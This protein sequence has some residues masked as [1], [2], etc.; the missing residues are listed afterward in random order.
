LGVLLLIA[1]P[2]ARVAFSLFGFIQQ[3]DRT[4]VLVTTI[5]LTILLLSLSGTV[6]LH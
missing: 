4:F 3:H 2:I 1:T 6:S 5:V